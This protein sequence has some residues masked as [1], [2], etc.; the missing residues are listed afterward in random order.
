[1]PIFYHL[2]RA[3]TLEVDRRVELIKDYTQ[4]P[5]IEIKDLIDKQKIVDRLNRLYPNGIS[6]HG[7]QYLLNTNLIVNDHCG[8]P[9]TFTLSN[10]MM[11]AIFEL[12]RRSEFSHLPSRMQS[13]FC[14]QTLSDLKKFDNNSRFKIYEIETDDYF[15][16]DMNLLYLGGQMIHAVEF[17]RM[18]WSGER[19]KQPHLEVLV[20]LP[21]KIGL[22][23]NY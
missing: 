12:V 2:D 4:Q 19:S 9:T 18:Y 10:P 3:G 20:P 8:N 5:L 13:V 16:G 17:A 21:T 22:E 1:M 11:E 15:I 7:I 14:W 6:Y 23:V